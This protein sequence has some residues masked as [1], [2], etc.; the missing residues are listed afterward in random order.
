MVNEPEDNYITG[1]VKLYRSFIEWEWF[2]VPNMVTIFVYCLLKANY[3]EKKWR[4]ITIKRGQ[5]VT[6]YETISK[7]TK[8]SIRSVRTCIKNLL[9]TKE[10]TKQTTNKYTMIT[11]CNYDAYQENKSLSDKQSDKQTTSERQSNDNQTTT[12]K[13]N[14]KLKNYKN[15]KNNIDY[16]EI[17]KIFNLTKHSNISEVQ[18]LTDKR[19]KMIN[20]ILAD[21]ELSDIGDAFKKVSESDF[22]N[23]KNGNGWTANFDWIFNKNNFIKILEGNYDNKEKKTINRQTEETIRQNLDT[24]GYEG[25]FR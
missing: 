24:T 17:V 8:L 15:D 20:S 10:L 11:I 12:N 6:S 13:N 21:F 3:E 18:K 4:G 7:E 1:F 5:F 9:L 2:D 14:N 23:G 25:A 16:N 22:L 19:K